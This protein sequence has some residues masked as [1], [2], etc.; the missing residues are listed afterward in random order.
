MVRTLLKS[1]YILGTVAILGGIGYLIAGFIFSETESGC[2]MFTKDTK[3]KLSACNIDKTNCKCGKLISTSDKK[4]INSDICNSLT[5]DECELPYCIGMCKS[6]S[7]LT[8][9]E[10]NS[11]GFLFQC[12]DTDVSDPNFI[13]YAYQE[14]S[15]WTFLANL[16]DFGSK[17]ATGVEKV[18]TDSLT[19]FQ[20]IINFIT[21]YL[22][23][24]II[25]FFIGY[26]GV[27]LLK[28]YKKKGPSTLIEE[29]IKNPTKHA[30]TKSTKHR[31]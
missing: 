23:I 2:Y 18:V 7:T 9:C 26:V 6:N 1:I 8:K 21:K 31:K 25:L 10:N 19:L 3:Y 29:N 16:I 27:A 14:Y 17:L 28:F 4:V 11:G 22:P 20:K 5:A 30:Y 12:T 13:Y 15:P 24:F